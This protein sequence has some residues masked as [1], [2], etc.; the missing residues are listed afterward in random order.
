[1]T[2]QTSPE[3]VAIAVGIQRNS[4][5]G[6][7]DLA[8]IYSDQA[9]LRTFYRDQCDPKFAAVAYYDWVEDYIRATLQLDRFFAAQIAVPALMT[10]IP[11][12]LRIAA[13]ESYAQPIS[14]LW[15]LL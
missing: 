6:R 3:T 15:A 13:P 2:V 5:T 9:K 8:L 14:N 11:Q 12:G 10:M 7:Y 4:T 1:M